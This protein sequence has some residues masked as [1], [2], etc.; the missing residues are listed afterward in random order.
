MLKIVEV[1]IWLFVS[2]CILGC[3]I[4]LFAVEPQMTESYW[5][6]GVVSTSIGIVVRAKRK[7]C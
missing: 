3:F 5:I 6:A 4:G 1:N 2:F 7:G